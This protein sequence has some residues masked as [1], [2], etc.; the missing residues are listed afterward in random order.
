MHDVKSLAFKTKASILLQMVQ[1]GDIVWH[2]GDQLDKGFHTFGNVPLTVQSLIMDCLELHQHIFDPPSLVINPFLLLRLV[3]CNYL[4]LEEFDLLVDSS[5]D[6]NVV[7]FLH[8]KTNLL[9]FDL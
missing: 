8:I 9:H 1:F 7:A 5:R 3:P 2:L 6:R 4:A